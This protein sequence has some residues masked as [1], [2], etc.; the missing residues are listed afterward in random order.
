MKYSHRTTSFSRFIPIIL[1][2]LITIVAVAAVIAIGRS[3]MGGGQPKQDEQVVIDKDKK[4]LLSTDAGRSIRLT[5]RG[6]IVADE[7]FR[8]YQITISP[9]TRVMTTYEGYLE[10]EIAT[11][12]FGNTSK[13]YEELV[14]ALDK[15]KMMDGRALTEKQNDL[16]GICASG[17]IYKFETLNNSQS[18]KTLWTSDC[19]GSKGS[20]LA[21]VN[22]VLDM[23]LK[24][25][26]GGK[27]TASEVGLSNEDAFFKF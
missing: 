2:I 5:V 24:Q 20:A 23:F 7:K 11:K 9:D 25:I 3:L 4:A 19:K 14:Y 12:N 26:P 27:K 6:P 10:K 16:R 21:N 22:E 1:V 15:R 17:K 18:V 13:A 8:S